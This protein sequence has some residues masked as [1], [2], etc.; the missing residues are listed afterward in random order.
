MRKIGYTIG[1]YLL[2]GQLTSYI[3]PV[4]HHNGVHIPWLV[5]LCSWLFEG[6]FVTL[7]GVW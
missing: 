7:F 2:V 6:A 3:L 1:M 5:K 4:L